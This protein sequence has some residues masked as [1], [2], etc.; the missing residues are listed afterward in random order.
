MT[1][2]APGS[3]T[4][5]RK[6]IGAGAAVLLVAAALSV[7]AVGLADA[8]VPLLLAG[9]LAGF[10]AGWSSVDPTATAHE[11]RAGGI[12]GLVAAGF[13]GVILVVTLMGL[14]LPA[15]ADGGVSLLFVASPLA[16]LTFSAVGFLGGYAGIG[17]RLAA[18]QSCG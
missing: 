8:V 6:P 14:D 3:R 15:T 1:G 12:H 17:F 7:L 18:V 4:L 16:F 9:I 5:Q 13:G 10:V 11:R 2:L